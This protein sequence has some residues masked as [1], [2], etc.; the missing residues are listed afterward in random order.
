LSPLLFNIYMSKLP[1]PPEGIDI[2]SYADDCTVM[3]SG[4]NLEHM[5]SSISAYL[6]TLKSWFNKRCLQYSTPKSIAT[7][8]TSWTQELGEG[9]INIQIDG[10]PIPFS[11]QVNILGVTFDPMLTFKAHAASVANKVSSRNK[12]LKSLAGRDWGNNK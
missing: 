1:T 7:L 4:T 12:V 5:C 2:I 8:F 10:D 6:T 11:S 3:M 9:K